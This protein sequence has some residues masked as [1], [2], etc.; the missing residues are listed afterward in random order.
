MTDS[1]PP[2]SD[3]PTGAEVIRTHLKTLPGSPGV[4]RMIDRRGEILYV[5]KAKNLRKRVAAYTNPARQSNRIARMIAATA[6]LIV[7]TT[8]TEVEAL[9]L[10]SNLIK[11]LKPRFNVLLRDDKSFPFIHIGGGHAWPR[12][13]KH[14]GARPDTG[15]LFGPFASAGAVNKTINI[16]QRAFM[17]R[18]CSDNVF[19]TRSRPCLLYQIKRCSAPCV[20]RIGAGDY[21]ATVAEARAFLGGKSHFVQKRLSEK[22]EAASGQQEF[23]IAATYR[24]RIKALTTIQAHQGINVASLVEADVIAAHQSAGMTCIQVFFFRA[25]QNWGNRAYF[26][27]HDKNHES[28]EVLAAFIGQFYDNKLPPKLVLVSETPENRALLEQALSVKAERRVRVTRPQRGMKREVIEHALRNAREA[29]GRRLSESE[30]QRR[31][32]EQLADVFGLEAPPSRIEVYDNSHISGTNAVGA[33]VVAGL[34]GLQKN[35]Y[36][37]FNIRGTDLAP[38]D[39]YAMMREVLQ[40]RFSRL[41]KEDPERA[42]GNWPDLVL[43]DGG[44]GQLSAVLEVAADLGLED[45]S[46]AAIAKGRERNAGRE[47]L[48]LPG[49][50]P[51][52]LDARSPVLYFL[53]RL[54]D[55]SHRFAIGAHRQRRAKA[56]G[57]SVLDRIPGIGARRKRAL[58]NHFGAAASVARAGLTDLETVDGISK[59]VA[60]VVYDHFHEDD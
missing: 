26:P 16:L 24:D 54:R 51:F 14:R 15:E 39:D 22:M 36:R 17:L 38:G 2:G 31:L 10:E 60:R 32:L 12:L 37:K 58:L 7:V 23:E 52:T 35:A 49:R 33:M 28:A 57:Q 8:H 42:S 1:P 44:A 21:Q 30:S 55:E 29:L 6:D 20:D 41:I 11:K 13:N 18:T 53:Q 4:Y 40:R 46:F 25:G 5:G 34:E 9:L 45:I 50:E 43:I 59:S 48:F 56:V 3:G 47:R 27:R 19:D